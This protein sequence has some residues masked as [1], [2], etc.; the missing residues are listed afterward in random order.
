MILFMILISVMP[1][2]VHPI[3]GASLGGVTIIKYF[4]F[5]AFAYALYYA[6]A[7]DR[8]PRL[9]KQP[10]IRWCACLFGLAAGS[11]LLSGSE[12]T[13]D[14]NIS[15]I[16]GSYFM[17]LFIT[18]VMTDSVN[19]LRWIL[20][21]GVGSVAWASAYIIREWQLYHDVWPGFRP[22]F[23]TGD[24]NY[25]AESCLTFLPFAVFS[26]L[27][28]G[29]VRWVRWFCGGCL[30]VMLPAF[31][32][33][34]SRGGFVGLC[35]AALFV[36]ARSKTNKLRLLAV[37]CVLVPLALFTPG[38]PLER[39]I[40]PTHGD[41]EGANNR[42][43]V[44]KAGLRMIADHPILG[45]GAGNFKPMTRKYA[46]VKNPYVSMAHNTYLEMLA[47]LG[48][49]GF[50]FFIATL[51][52]A[53]RSLERT[54]QAT[55]GKGP[56]MINQAARGLQA[57]LVGCCVSIFFLSGQ[58]QKLFWLII[59]LSAALPPLA[60]QASRREKA[61]AAAHMRRVGYAV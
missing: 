15:I 12:L 35:A 50:A 38:S 48:I 49:V 25:F 3:W 61:R 57:G 51:V 22:G 14:S 55:R 11:F 56:A 29:T 28:N 60:L 46:D 30:A 18:L 8:S 2:S 40:N 32:L 27:E 42:T 44:W 16:Y 4:G 59:F 53:Y 24:S 13:L 43:I 1:F 41:T 7:N 23:I 5:I 6:Y 36:V 33:S 45:V 9:F 17:T 52:A 10:Q 47:E 20:V 31:L 19:A 54:H 37:G 39:F 21:S 34:G 26:V 58:Y